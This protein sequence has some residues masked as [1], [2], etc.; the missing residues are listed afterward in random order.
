MS[1]SWNQAAATFGAIAASLLAAIALW[2]VV[3]R[4]AHVWA[5]RIIVR[6]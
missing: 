3:E 4:P 2:Y 1:W 6:R 5:R